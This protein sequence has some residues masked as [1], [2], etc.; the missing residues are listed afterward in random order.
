MFRPFWFLQLPR[1]LCAFGPF[2]LHDPLPGMPKT[3]QFDSLK[4]KLAMCRKP[5]ATTINSLSSTHQPVIAFE[6]DICYI[7]LL[8]AGRYSM[9]FRT[10]GE[11]RRNRNGEMFSRRE[12]DA[13]LG[14][15]W[16]P[17][18]NILSVV[19]VTHVTPNFV[20]ASAYICLQVPQIMFMTL[21]MNHSC[22]LSVL[23]QH[24]LWKQNTHS[25]KISRELSLWKINDWYTNGKH[26]S[27]SHV[28][29]QFPETRL[30]GWM[31][32]SPSPK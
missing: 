18:R 30:A 16:A 26:R 31:S 11:K 21:M 13:E 10:F 17:H 6:L 32:S 24:F 8:F 28:S 29:S 4:I 27:T 3:Q 15:N 5:P 9:I 25:N 20:C 2:Q 22:F 12:P 19:P 14:S 23:S 7:L 1:F